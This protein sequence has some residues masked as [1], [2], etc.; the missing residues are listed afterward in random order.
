M[1]CSRDIQILD[2][3]EN[4]RFQNRWRHHGHCYIMEITLSLFLL[5]LKYDQNE[6]WLN[7][8]VLYDKH[9]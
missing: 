2:L 8:T 9:F 6:I 4:H 5:N 7:T 1:F 3:C